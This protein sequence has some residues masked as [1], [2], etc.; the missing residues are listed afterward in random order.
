MKRCGFSIIECMVVIV[1]TSLIF[2]YFSSNYISIKKYYNKIHKDIDN[3]LEVNYLFQALKKSIMFAG[4]SS[5]FNLN[6]IKTFDARNNMSLK[7]FSI[8]T[9]NEPRI[10]IQRIDNDVFKFR[11]ITLNSILVSVNQFNFD[12][13]KPVILFNCEVAEVQFIKKIEKN[14][15]DYKLFFNNS[16]NFQYKESGFIAY[17][18][19]EE[20]YNQIIDSNQTLMYRHLKHKEQLSQDI[21]LKKV[22]VGENG[23]VKII[24]SNFNNV[25]FYVRPRCL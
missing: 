22:T 20:F 12:L 15:G 24:W 4:C 19:E 18:V 23:L 21:F 7:A 5:C 14:C 8:N 1:I 17:F 2:V 13:S 16:L 25:E 9:G 6:R 3:E 11:Q 10:K